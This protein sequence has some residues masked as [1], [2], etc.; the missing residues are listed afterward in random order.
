MKHTGIQRIKEALGINSNVD[1]EDHVG[2]GGGEAAPVAHEVGEEGFCR[3]HGP[4]GFVAPDRLMLT[5]AACSTDVAGLGGKNREEENN[6]GNI[7]NGSG[8]P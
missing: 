6:T 7:Q 4:N 2:V 3:E 1:W 5:L 8:P